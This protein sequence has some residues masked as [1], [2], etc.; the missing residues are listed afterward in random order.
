MRKE[1]KILVICALV[2][3]SCGLLSC[4]EC[5][6]A[7]VSDTIELQAL[8][9]GSRT[10]QLT[11]SGGEGTTTIYRQ[12]PGD[13][14]LE[15]IATTTGN[16]WTDHHHRC[17]CGDT[18]G[19]SISRSSDVGFA[20]VMVSD[21]EPTAMASWG[22]V[23]VE[24]EQV[25]LRWTASADTDI[26]GYLVCEGNPSVVIDTVFGRNNT[27]Y[28]YTV[29]DVTTVHH[30]RLCAFDSCRQASAL[31][32]V[33]NNMVLVLETNPCS[34]TVNASWN[35]YQNMPSDVGNY[36]LWVSE[37]GAGFRRVTQTEAAVHGA[38]FEVS[39]SCMML[40][41]YVTA[42][43]ADGQTTALSNRVSSIFSTTERP[44]YFYLRKVSVAGDGASVDIIAQTDPAFAG[45]DYRLYRTV[46]GRPA[47]LIANP[48]PSPDGT[49][50]WHDSDVNP[51]SE[52][53]GYYFGV[54]DGCGRNEMH[55]ATGFTIL[56]ELVTDGTGTVL[57]WN[58]YEG[59]S[60]ATQYQIVSSPLD[61]ESWQVVDNIRENEYLLPE[62]DGV[63]RYKVFAF[64]GPDSEHHRGD[65]L[66]SV[67]VFHRPHT[68]IWMPNA[69]TPTET[70]N[71]TVKPVS[72]YINPEGYS[73]EVYSRQGLKVFSTTSTEAAWDGR[74]QGLL[75]PVGTFLYKITYRQNDGT[76]QELTGTLLLVR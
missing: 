45:T 66:Q 35:G 68:V 72:Q 42:V 21:N 70:S 20:A 49:L 58:A 46:A 44:A 65:S 62:G 24:E 56:P 15:L 26:M 59:W 60:G 73:F 51:A 36:E 17:V 19:Y 54:V 18:V 69:F 16:T 57:R 47:A 27:T 61:Y 34:R 32:E 12:Y 41:A 10:V 67:A 29:G 14:Q 33:C 39:E 5:L 74:Y 8:Q 71:N 31:T 50:S 2:A 52:P 28:T 22:V 9:T 64:E 30:F 1:S 25:R 40:A 75:L 48:M 3:L 23:S 55:T 11:W 37:D 63:Q 4:G 38:T 7:A 13:E 6:A 43:S 53:C 76:D